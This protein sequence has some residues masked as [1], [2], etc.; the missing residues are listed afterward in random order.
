MRP[1][2]FLPGHDPRRNAGGIDPKLKKLR[3]ALTRLDKD[4]LARLGDI[5]AN[6]PTDEAVKAIA[7]WARYRIPVPKE[8]AQDETTTS[9]VPPALMALTAEQV[10][11][12][13]GSSDERDT[14]DA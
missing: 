5:I 2:G 14:P 9:R 1:G 7:I 8:V 10:L 3:R 12:L 4:A 11:A 6:G 13:A